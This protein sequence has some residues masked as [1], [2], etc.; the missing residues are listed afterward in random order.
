LKALAISIAEE[1]EFQF[2][3]IDVPLA[4]A[5]KSDLHLINISIDDEGHEENGRDWT[6]QMGLNLKYCAK[7]RKETSGIQDQFPLSVWGLFSNPSPVSVV[8][9]LKWLCRKARTPYSIIGIITSSGTAATAAEVK[10]EVKKEICTTVNVCEDDSRQH[11]FQQPSGLHDSDDRE[12]KLSCSEENDH[13]RHCIIDIPI[14]VAEYPMKHQVCEGAVGVSTCNDGNGAICSSDSHDSSLLATSPVDVTGDQGC[15]QSTDLSSSSTFSVRQFLNDESTSVEGSMKCTSNHEYLQ[16]QD[17]D[18]CLQVQLDQEN[19]RLHN[20]SNRTSVDPCLKEDLAISEE[21]HGSNVSADPENEHGCAK[22]SNCSDKTNQSAAVNQ[23]E[24]H[25]AGAVPDKR[26]SRCDEMTCS[27]DVQ[28]S[29]TFSCLASADVHGSTQHQSVLHDL[30]SDELQVDSNHFVVKAVEPKSNSYAKHESPQMDILISEDAQAAATTAVP[31]HDGKSVHAGSNSFDILLGALA[32]E[33]KVTDAPG[34]DEVGKASLTLMTLA[35]NDHYADEFAEGEVVKV[36]KTNTIFGAAKDDEQVDRSHGFHLSDVVSRSIGNSDRTEI[37]CYVRRKHKR[38]KDSQ[39]NTDSAQ[40]LGN[41][42]RSPCESLR[43][44]TK[45]A[46]VE[47]VEVSAGKRGKRAKV[48]SFQCDIDLC[49][50]TFESRAELNA[51]KRNICTDE[52]CGKRFSSHKYLKRHQCV[53]SEIRP[54]KCPWDGCE[55]T[56]KWLWAQ[57]EHVR[58]HTGE[59]PYKCSAPSCGQTFRYVSDYSRHRKKFNHY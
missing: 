1:I 56:F 21:K 29:I 15:I 46:V 24:T 43:P 22:T 8:P 18:E 23:L 36:A 5:S 42:V 11:I 50:M 53:H 38:K 19:M 12:N 3:C 7:L 49:D 54:F 16:S 47:T 55:M 14:A 52:S 6:S 20:N 37:I 9:N 26:K 48:G 57:T 59:R 45:P 4:N 17:R 27:A 35:S 30:M 44:R 25:D 32:E 33:S 51:H 10:P 31:G 41:F 39:S 2:D 58:V 40:S 34:K 28:C 13:D